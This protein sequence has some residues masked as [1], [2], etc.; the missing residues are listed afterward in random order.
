MQTVG[1][2]LHAQREKKK[3]TLEDIHKFVKIHPK[4]LSA[5]ENDDYSVFSD[6]VHAK[7]FLK[8]YADF[9]ELDVERMLAFWRRE[10]EGG[11]EREHKK[12][13]RK[14]DLK[15]LDSPKIRLTPSILFTAVAG[16]LITVFFAYLFFQYKNYSGAPSLEVLS[17]ENNIIVVTDVLDI[18]GK[19]ERDSVL[20]INNQR[21]ILNMDGSFATSIRLSE[22]INTLSLKAVNK[23]GKE[24][25]IIRTIIYRPA[26]AIIEST[27][28]TESSE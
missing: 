23:L 28:S 26:P 20:F 8:I 13:R 4:Y 18:T 24:T 6:K 9:L 27:E 16:I 7:G 12:E 2:I 10:Y 17:P 3:L 11:F 21:V 5:L 14:Y 19:T 15:V 25:E 22:G 1:Q